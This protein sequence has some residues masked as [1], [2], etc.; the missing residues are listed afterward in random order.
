MA[1]SSTKHKDHRASDPWPNQPL[2]FFNLDRPRLQDLVQEQNS[3]KRCTTRTKALE[4]LLVE[5]QKFWKFNL[6]QE[7]KLWKLFLVQEP[8]L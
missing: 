1:N 7:P 4:N 8:K 2:H 3:G 5:E 6:V